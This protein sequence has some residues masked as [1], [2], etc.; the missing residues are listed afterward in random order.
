MP[1]LNKLLV[2]IDDIF[3]GGKQKNLSELGII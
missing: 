3:G 2:K 1:W